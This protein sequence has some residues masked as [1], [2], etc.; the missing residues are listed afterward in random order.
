M[1]PP[2]PKPFPDDKVAK[3][4]NVPTTQ[5]AP[6]PKATCDKVRTASPPDIHAGLCE[7]KISLLIRPI[8][9][10]CE[11]KVKANYFSPMV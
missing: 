3:D 8:L 2:M 10:H 7:A 6:A 5:P 9:T 4:A 11:S 1:A